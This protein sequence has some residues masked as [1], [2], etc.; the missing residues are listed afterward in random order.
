M[1]ETS[2]KN[3]ITSLQKKWE[4]QAIA[5]CISISLAFSIIIIGLLHYFFQWQF[6]LAILIFLASLSLILFLYPAWRIKQSGVAKFLNQ[7]FS[8]L[9]DSSAL[10]LHSSQ[11]MNLLE[12]LQ[13][14]K[15][16]TVLQ[17]L[18]LPKPFRKKLL[19]SFFSLVIACVVFYILSSINHHP[20]DIKSSILN[21]NSQESIS[22]NSLPQIRDFFVQI[23]PPSYTHIQ[24]TK[25]N[26]FD[27]KAPEGANVHWQIFT[28]KAL[29]NCSLIFNDSSVLQ[30]HQDNR[31]A[32]N[33]SISKPM[34]ASSFYQLKMDDAV[35]DL[36]K[37]EIIKDEPPVINIQSPKPYTTIDYGEPLKALLHV[38][39][40]DDYGIKNASI[41]ATVASGNGE[42]VHFKQQQLF[43][44]NSFASNNPNYDLTKT[45]NLSSFDMKPG[46]ELYFYVKTQ[47]THEQETKSDM[48]IIS[49]PDT[50]Q[51]MSL[52]GL[53]TGLDIK[54]EYFRSER[55]I[56]IE[57]E[58][59]LKEKDT[60]SVQSFHDR[61]NNLGIDQKLLRL[62]YGKFLGEENEENIGDTK[63]ENKSG[64]TP[65]SNDFGNAQKIIEQ[66]TDKHDNA[67]DA[68]FFDASIKEQLKATLTEM[69][70][71]ELRLR[72]F[73]TREALPYEY[74]ALR[75][76]K[77]LQQKSRAFVAKTGVKTTPLNIEKRL[78][79][80]LSKIIEPQKKYALDDELNEDDISRAAI[81]ILEELKSNQFIN[82]ASFNIL[83]ES[84]RQI[85][86]AARSSPSQYLSSYQAIKKILHNL[87]EKKSS[88]INDII[89]TQ[90]ALQK[91]I[92]PAYLSLQPQKESAD[93]NLAQQYFKNLKGKKD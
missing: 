66:F 34:H 82:P 57:T 3:I 18:T 40:K 2:G 80:D 67:E 91:I 75:L 86:K 11:K 15:I 89:I 35:S 16:E 12:S 64:S 5:F 30:L 9:E 22:E 45:I 58:Q 32:T 72:T 59:L 24:A 21:H 38:F 76:L 52:E 13:K 70:N 14:R 31:E 43:F 87:N 85:G 88:A 42:A 20:A 44:D 25:Q 4:M 46:D 33:W 63:P 61:S 47:D 23:E 54:P 51:L 65:P 69:W 37:I 93:M 17:R 27:I 50:A 56:I 10:L 8:E 49:L 71:A 68:S 39:L 78:T 62:R 55:Q 53:A 92:S 77:D 73:K 74:K 29:K 7:S 28:N 60:I 81:S 79:G 26:Q 83:Q 90:Q 84:A 41:V 36:H 6:W 48:L 19:L 1:A